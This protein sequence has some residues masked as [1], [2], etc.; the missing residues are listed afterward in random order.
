MRVDYFGPKNSNKFC[1][2]G[3]IVNE[4]NVKGLKRFFE[5]LKKD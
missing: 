3:I 2:N 4:N 1:K 5:D